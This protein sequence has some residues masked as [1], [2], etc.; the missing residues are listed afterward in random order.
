MAKRLRRNGVDVGRRARPDT[1]GAAARGVGDE[2]VVCLRQAEIAA[3]GRC[4]SCC[5]ASYS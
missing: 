4:A 2:C 1:G 5:G 3:D